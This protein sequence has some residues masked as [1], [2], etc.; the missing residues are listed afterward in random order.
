[1]ATR[2]A[3]IKYVVARQFR[4]VEIASGM[5]EGGAEAPKKETITEKFSTYSSKREAEQDFKSETEQ[6]EFRRFLCEVKHQKH[7]G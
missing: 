2:V 6:T 1:M 4:T 5:I 7:L 3:P